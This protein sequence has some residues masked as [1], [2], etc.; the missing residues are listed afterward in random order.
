MILEFAHTA[1]VERTPQM[2]NQLDVCP[3]TPEQSLFAAEYIIEPLLR[4]CD[5]ESFTS[6][7]EETWRALLLGQLHN[8]REIEV[9][10]I[11]DSDVSPLPYLS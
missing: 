2:P 6:K 10:L 5:Y 1:I 11:A 9:M 8:V 7:I 4:K 3:M